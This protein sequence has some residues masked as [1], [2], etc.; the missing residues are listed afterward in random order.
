MERF[1][2][3]SLNVINGGISISITYAVVNFGTY[4]AI[5]PNGGPGWDRRVQAIGS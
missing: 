4:L 1:L 5:N 2:D 3:R